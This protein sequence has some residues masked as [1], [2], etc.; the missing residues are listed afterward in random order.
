MTTLSNLNSDLKQIFDIDIPI[1]SG[2]GRSLDDPY[3]ISSDGSPE[4]RDY[5]SI[6]YQVINCLCNLQK[7]EWKL[8]QQRLHRVDGRKIDS[9]EIEVKFIDVE[10][11]IYRRKKQTYYFDFTD[12]LTDL[13]AH[14]SIES[15]QKPK[16]ST[17]DKK[18][19]ARESSRPVD[20]SGRTMDI[21]D[22][23]YYPFRAEKAYL[24]NSPLYR[25]KRFLNNNPRKAHIATCQASSKKDAV[26]K[27]LDTKTETP[28]IPLESP[29]YYFFGIREKKTAESFAELISVRRE[30]FALF[31][32]KDLLGKK[33]RLQPAQEREIIVF[34]YLLEWIGLLLST[35]P[36]R[37]I[38]LVMMSFSYLTST[39][40]ENETERFISIYSLQDEIRQIHSFHSPTKNLRGVVKILLSRLFRKVSLIGVLDKSEL[41]FFFTETLK[42]LNTNIK[43]NDKFTKKYKVIS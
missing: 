2:S 24:R 42:Q 23:Y 6:E 35:M 18:R 43:N 31:I 20:L 25:F 29:A 37:E 28:P 21:Y 7:Y 16:E 32:Q 8:V 1:F 13:S 12:C 33:I 17:H 15:L 3:V 11:G 38:Q 36:R 9:M 26:R 40:S 39:D 41:D 19:V 22:V 34:T 5:S 27:A 30:L 4:S 10:H 14:N